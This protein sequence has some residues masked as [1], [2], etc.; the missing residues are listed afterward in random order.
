[1]GWWSE[2]EGRHHSA[3]RMED[4]RRPAL[5][6]C[7]SLACTGLQMRVAFHAFHAKLECTAIVL[8]VQRA[9]AVVL[10]ATVQHLVERMEAHAYCVNLENTITIPLE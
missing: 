6:F 10:A 3:L 7:A 4:G 5:V 2:Q 1:M 8:L 9:S